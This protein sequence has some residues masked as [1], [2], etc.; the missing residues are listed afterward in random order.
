MHGTEGRVWEDP[1]MD[2]DDEKGQIQPYES[3]RVC[4][5]FQNQVN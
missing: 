3:I 4:P 1:L 5:G 2:L